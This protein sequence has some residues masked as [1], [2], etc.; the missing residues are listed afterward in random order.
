[1]STMVTELACPELAPFAQR[2]VEKGRSAGYTYATKI[3]HKGLTNK[4]ISNYLLWGG[5]LARPATKG[6][7]DAHPTSSSNLFLGNP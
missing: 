4:K 6:G 3:F 5:R 2:L 7:Q 1:M